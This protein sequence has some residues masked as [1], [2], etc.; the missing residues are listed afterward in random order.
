[1]GCSA[2]RHQK[3]ESKWLAWL[4]PWNAELFV[5]QTE[6]VNSPP[7]PL[8]IGNRITL[9]PFPQVELGLTH[10]VQWGGGGRD[11][12]LRS[13]FY[14]LKSLHSNADNPAEQP[15]D[16]G[17]SLAGFDLRVRCP[18]AWRCAGY[19]QAIGEDKAN[20]IPTKYLGVIGMEFWPGDAGQRFFAEYAQTGCRAAFFRSALLGCAYTSLNRAPSRARFS[21]SR[22]DGRFDPDP[23]SKPAW[24]VARG[25]RFNASGEFLREVAAF[26]GAAVMSLLPRSRSDSAW[27][28]RGAVC[29]EKQ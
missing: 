27:L 18:S 19:A 17:N 24:R 6:D 16:P 9:R 26:T 8:L 4:G 3:S 23:P 10:M 22:R 11:N 25:V 14:A 21:I 20:Y 1:M 28:Q 15:L 5:A 2:R 7:H 13:F 29:P 12:S